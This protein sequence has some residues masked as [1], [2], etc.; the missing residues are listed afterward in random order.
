MTLYKATAEGPVAMTPEEEAEHIA[1]L[2]PAVEVPSEVMFRQA[3]TQMRLTAHGQ[4]NLWD[5]ACAAVEAI[6]NPAQ[7][8]VMEGFLYDSSVYER[9]RPELLALA[10][11]L[12]LTSEQ[13]DTLF[14]AAKAR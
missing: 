13:L 10:T 12:G 5:A 3:K 6:T 7:K 4:T 14:T 1:S 2:V 8:V 11:A 9:N